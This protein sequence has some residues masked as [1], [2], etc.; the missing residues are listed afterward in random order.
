VAKRINSIVTYNFDNLLEETLHETGLPFKTIYR[1]L[2]SPLHN[3]LAINHVHGFL[4]EHAENYEDLTESLLVFSE[5]GYHSLIQDPY[6]WSNIVQLNLLRENT[7]LLIGLSMTDPNLRRLLA[8]SSKRVE[9]PKHYVI[10][11]KQYFK[12]SKDDKEDIRDGALQVF[13]NV[14]QELQEKTFQEF[15]LNIIWIESYEEIPGIL[16]SIRA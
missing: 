16:D 13:S 1:D 15:G 8:I 6:V 14:N 7:C 11:K 5:E 10:L 2:Y 4:P 9:E 3:E 12:K